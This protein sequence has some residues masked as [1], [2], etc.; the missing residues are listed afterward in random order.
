M[1]GPAESGRRAGGKNSPLLIWRGGGDRAARRLT[2][3]WLLNLMLGAFALFCGIIILAAWLFMIRDWLTSMRWSQVPGT[4]RGSVVE[5]IKRTDPYRP[6]VTQDGFRA[7]LRYA[8]S[9]ED[10]TYLGNRYSATREPFF[11]NQA[12]AN[13]FLKRFPL[14][15]R[16]SVRVN[17]DDAKQSLLVRELTAPDAMPGYLGMACVFLGVVFSLF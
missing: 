2:H 11:A 17:P 3:A 4:V 15:G 16:L 10:Q 8:Y 14:G 13:R 9:V 5:P 6:W 7:V 12:D 1:R